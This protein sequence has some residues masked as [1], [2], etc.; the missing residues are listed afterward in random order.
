MSALHTPRACSRLFTDVF[1][2][3]RVAK[4]LFRGFPPFRKKLIPAFESALRLGGI[5]PRAR[6]RGLETVSEHGGR[7]GACGARGERRLE[8]GYR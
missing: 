6:G 2:S 3:F 8:P 7:S 4:N 1:G 5:L